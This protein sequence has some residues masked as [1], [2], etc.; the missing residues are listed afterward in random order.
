VVIGSSLLLK[1]LLYRLIPSAF[2][3]SYITN[4]TGYIYIIG[5]SLS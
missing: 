1:V 3:L 2:S 5:G 4:T